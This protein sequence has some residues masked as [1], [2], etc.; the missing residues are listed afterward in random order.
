MSFHSRPLK[1]IISSKALLE[2]SGIH[3]CFVLIIWKYE[4]SCCLKATMTGCSSIHHFTQKADTPSQ[5]QPRCYTSVWL[6]AS[7]QFTEALERHCTLSRVLGCCYGASGFGVSPNEEPK[8]LGIPAEFSMEST[9]G[10]TGVRVISTSPLSSNNIA[11]GRYV[12]VDCGTSWG[13][14]LPSLDNG[15]R[16]MTILRLSS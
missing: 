6:Q 2:S 9:C 1:F 14:G 13:D 4:C 15:A 11:G 10:S 12:T 8:E 3:L 7:M 5:A 16:W